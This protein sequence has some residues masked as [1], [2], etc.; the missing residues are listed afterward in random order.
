MI[1][2]IPVSVWPG[3]DRD[4]GLGP[5]LLASNAD[6]DVAEFRGELRAQTDL[7]NITRLDMGELRNDMGDLRTDMGDLRTEVGDLR[8]EMVGRFDQLHGGMETLRELIQ[9]LIDR[10]QA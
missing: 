8:T 1:P 3:P 4:D 5:D 10:D 7:I 9:T 2:V 6:R